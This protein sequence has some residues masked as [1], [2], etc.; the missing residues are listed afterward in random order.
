MNI[1]VVSKFKGGKQFNIIMVMVEVLN[2]VIWCLISMV[3]HA[4][5]TVF[6]L[7][8]GFT[9]ARS[10]NAVEAPSDRILLMMCVASRSKPLEILEIFWRV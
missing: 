3:L 6:E 2:K 5:E 1:L 7:E 8:T 9:V 4:I 10:E